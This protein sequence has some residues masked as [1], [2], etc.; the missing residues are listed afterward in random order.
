MFVSVSVFVCVPAVEVG[1]ASTLVG[2]VAVGVVAVDAVAVDN[3][4]G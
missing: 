3:M 2:V 1:F 4:A